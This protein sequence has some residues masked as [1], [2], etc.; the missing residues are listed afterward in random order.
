[1]EKLS[2]QNKVVDGLIAAI[3]SPYTVEEG[4]GN[5]VDQRIRKHTG[6][7]LQAYVEPEKDKDGNL[8]TGE[9]LARQ[10]DLQFRAITSIAA[11]LAALK[12]IKADIQAAKTNGT[13][14]AQSKRDLDFLLKRVE[15]NIQENLKPIVEGR[16]QQLLDNAEQLLND[17]DNSNEIIDAVRLNMLDQF[18]VD[19]FDSMVGGI[20]GKYGKPEEGSEEAKRNLPYSKFNANDVIDDI[21]NSVNEDYLLAQRIEQD[22]QETAQART[23]AEARI[24]QSK[25]KKEAKR[26]AREERKKQE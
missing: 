22:W 5:V 7:I 20:L 15:Q 14:F 8:I 21:L 12:Q 19:Y 9:A 11:N 16:R 25:L 18:E 13:Q 17:L 24:R 4:T 6:D 26:K 23:E 3:E 10:S 1:M 2:K